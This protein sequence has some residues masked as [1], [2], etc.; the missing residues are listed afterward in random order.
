MNDTALV[1]ID[2]DGESLRVPAGASLA[3]VLL[4]NGRD[5]LGK[6]GDGSTRGLFCG[7]GVCFECR[8]TVDGRSPV[9]ACMTPVRAGMRVVIGV[10]PDR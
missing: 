9:R 7:M 6:R 1:V 2:V 4:D 10:E 5:V 8:V 3:A